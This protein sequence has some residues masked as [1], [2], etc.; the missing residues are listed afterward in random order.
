[1]CF[2]FETGFL[3]SIKPSL[4]ELSMVRQKVYFEFIRIW[5]LFYLDLELMIDIFLDFKVVEPHEDFEKVL[6][7]TQVSKKLT[8][9]LVTLFYA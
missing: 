4:T 3:P 2:L 8:Q 6:Y 7:T 5:G 9:V 1:M